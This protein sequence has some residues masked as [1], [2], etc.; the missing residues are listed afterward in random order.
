MVWKRSSNFCCVWGCLWRSCLILQRLRPE[1]RAPRR[2]R[3]PACC[4]SRRRTCRTTCHT[5]ESCTSRT[6]RSRSAWPWRTPRRTDPR[7]RIR[8][9]S[10]LTLQ[11]VSD[12]KKRI[13]KKASKTMVPKGGTI[14]FGSARV[15]IGRPVE[16]CENWTLHCEVCGLEKKSH[17]KFGHFL[18]HKKAPTNKKTFW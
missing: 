16:F 7:P 17:L 15:W 9:S 13:P 14:P 10:W 5:A 3:S 8:L 6:C 12:W 11:T 1:E 4:S 18:F 2:R